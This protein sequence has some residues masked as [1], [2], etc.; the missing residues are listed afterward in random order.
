MRGKAG[1]KS[2]LVRNEDLEGTDNLCQRNALI[3]LPAFQCLRV[4]DKDYKVF[5]LALVVDFDLVWCLAA[6]HDCFS[7]EVEVEMLW[8]GLDWIV[9][10]RSVNANWVVSGL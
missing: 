5:V 6:S 7:F 9:F 4:V 8:I 2:L 3:F 1:S 10:L